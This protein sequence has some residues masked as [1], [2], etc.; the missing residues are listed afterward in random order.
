LASTRTAPSTATPSPSSDEV[1]EL[2]PPAD[3]GFGG[4]ATLLVAGQSALIQELLNRG[5]TKVTP[6]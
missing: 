5:Y 3:S 2:R 4:T 6:K 1:V